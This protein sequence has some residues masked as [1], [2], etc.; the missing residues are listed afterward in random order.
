METQEPKGKRNKSEKEDYQRKGRRVKMEMKRDKK[1]DFYRPLTGGFNFWTT[2][3]ILRSSISQ[4]VELPTYM[5][6][7][8]FSLNVTAGMLVGY[9][10]SLFNSTAI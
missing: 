5:T 8:L 6:H 9:S 4:P 1:K 3:R 10:C 7:D 2:S